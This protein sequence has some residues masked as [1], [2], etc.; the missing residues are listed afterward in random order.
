MNVTDI[1]SQAGRWLAADPDPIT[2]AELAP[3]LENQDSAALLERFGRR[4]EFGTAGMRAVRGAGPARMNRLLVRITTA[5]LGRVLLER[6]P[7]AAGRGVVVGFDARHQSAAMARD[8]CAVL[9]GMAITRCR[10]HGK[11]V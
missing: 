5:M 4:L 3:L 7:Q 9:A 10:A 2:R 6:V 8:A 1:L 11:F